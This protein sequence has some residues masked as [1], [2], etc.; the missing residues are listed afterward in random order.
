M[1]L[2]LLMLGKTRRPELRAVIDDY[3][4]RIARAMPVEVNEVRDED[5][6]LKRLDADRAATVLLTVS[7][8]AGSVTSSAATLTVSLKCFVSA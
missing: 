2:R 7:N 4:K 8:T 3:V 6:A 5:A 1:K